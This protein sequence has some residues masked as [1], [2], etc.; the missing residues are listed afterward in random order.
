MSRRAGSEQRPLLVAA[1]ADKTWRAYKR[2]VK[3]FLAWCREEEETVGNDVELLDD[4]LVVYFHHLYASGA[5]M[6]RASNLKAGVQA[7]CPRVKRVGLH[8]AARCLV[9]WR[10]LRPSESWAPITWPMTVAL[11]TVIAV[12]SLRMA[13]AVLLAFDCYLRAG[14]LLGL[15]KEDV[16]LPGDRRLAGAGGEVLGA[17]RLRRTK[18]GREQSVTIRDPDVLQLLEP[19]VS[20]TAK[21]RPV[22]PFKAAQLRAA[23]RGACETLGLPVSFVLHSL[24][25]GGATRDY[26]RGV[27]MADVMTRGR[28]RSRESATRY[29]QSGRALLLA[30]DLD[31]ATAVWAASLTA[32]VVASVL[33]ANAE[34][35]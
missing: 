31:D 21:G 12:D 27:P 16:A 14:E 25:H 19:I 35:K 24:R 17:L 11:A 15:V 10:R 13:T 32:D 8:A 4:L 23:F 1:V 9:G 3:A 30:V 33:S 2:E 28:W 6:Q 29:I 34:R 26:L 20:A 7:I 18:T 5:G 22:F